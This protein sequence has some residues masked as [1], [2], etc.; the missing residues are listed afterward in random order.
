MLLR[1]IFLLASALAVCD[2]GP[3]RRD[4]G[5]KHYMIVMKPGHHTNEVEQEASVGATAPPEALDLQ[6]G[7]AL[8]T[9]ATI[10]VET[11]T[12]LPSVEA[13]EEVQTFSVNPSDFMTTAPSI[14]TTPW[15]A[16]LA[17]AGDP[18]S[19]LLPPVD[20]TVDWHLDRID[21]RGLP[22]NL[23]YNVT[24][25][26][27]GVDIYIVDTG[28]ANALPEFEGRAFPFH[29]P[30]DGLAGDVYG[31]GTFVAALA[32]GR[33]HG[34]AKCATLYDVR[35]LGADGGG[36]TVDI[37][38]GLDAVLRRP[39]KTRRAIVNMSLGGKG[40]SQIIEWYIAAL[41]ADNVLV[42]A[43][44]G[45]SDAGDNACTYT[46]GASDS[47]LTVG[48]LDMLDKM[49]VWSNTG[50]CVKVLAPGVDVY[51]TT[52]DGVD[53][54]WSG[55]S[56]AAPI[57][58]GGAALLW[59]DATTLTARQVF[60]AVLANG[61]PNLASTAAATTLPDSTPNLLL[62][63]QFSVARAPSAADLAAGIGGTPLTVC[64]GSACGSWTFSVGV[65]ENGILMRS[66]SG[67][68][69]VRPFSWSGV[70]MSVYTMVGVTA[71]S[72][73]SL[74]TTLPDGLYFEGNNRMSIRGGGVRVVIE[75]MSF[76]NDGT[77][78]LYFRDGSGGT[79]SY[80]TGALVQ[81][82]ADQVL[83]LYSWRGLGVC[84]RELW[85]VCPLHAVSSQS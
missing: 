52:A 37:V 82:T 27:A 65:N 33:R 41:L 29:S 46:P 11:F 25:C 68:A 24:Q 35:V 80:S 57:A 1:L 71:Y 13:V 22:L 62:F 10:D 60:R 55:T 36:D 70:R 2:A 4:R 83:W 49:P 44:A 42:V 73:A 47:A 48:A 3:T 21:Q 12:A 84:V 20:N 31:H 69:L 34:V 38:Q 74:A 32:G 77:P 28:I 75:S 30:A 59:S 17:A 53:Q 45:N 26:G 15:A 76:I 79:W 18:S 9:D 64:T 43:A 58:A 39:D 66:S 8:V 85:L 6:T 40:R 5:K 23:D 7:A 61:T 50:K 54:A 51:S 63:V 56:M 78:R 67:A 19:T 72:T 81:L 16:K 14:D